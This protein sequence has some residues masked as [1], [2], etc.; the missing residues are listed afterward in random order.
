MSNKNP[1]PFAG[2]FLLKGSKVQQNKIVYL[3]GLAI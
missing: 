3:C 2:D 1:Q